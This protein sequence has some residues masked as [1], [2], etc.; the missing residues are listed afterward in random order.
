MPRSSSLEQ[1]P[2]LSEDGVRNYNQTTAQNDARLEVKQRLLLIP[3]MF[4]LL[5][6]WGT[7]QFFYSLI[8]S[9]SIH[10]GCVS[11]A[12]AKTFYVL[13]IAQVCI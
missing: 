13:G 3:L 10:K 7:M 6:I 5:R 4:I 12:D 8:K 11:I 1:H 2:I 9:G